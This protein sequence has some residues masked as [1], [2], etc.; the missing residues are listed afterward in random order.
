MLPICDYV[1]TLEMG[2]AAQMTYIRKKQEATLE[3]GELQNRGVSVL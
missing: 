1:D 2:R 3:V